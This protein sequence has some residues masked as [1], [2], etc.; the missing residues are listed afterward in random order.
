MTLDLASRATPQFQRRSVALDDFELRADDGADHWTFVGLAATVDHPYQVRDMMGEFTETIAEGAF[1][2]TL[3][4][5][6]AK[7]SLHVNHQHGKAI[8]LATRAAGTL[9]LVADPNLRVRA[10]LDPARPDVQ[11]LRSALRRGEITEMSIGFNDVKDGAVWNESYTER[12]VTD[13]RLRECSVVEDGCNDLTAAS[14]RS[15]VQEFALRGG[16]VDPGEARRA[17]AYLEQ[18]LPPA[19]EAG[20]TLERSGLVV[21]DQLIELYDKRFV[22]PFG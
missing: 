7:V 16:H 10:Q 20:E 8:P 22:A 1:K 6:T 9:D 5:P 14:I 2:R 12:S 21:T 11:I 17:I 19:D 3:N 15:L 13:M 4:D 18:F